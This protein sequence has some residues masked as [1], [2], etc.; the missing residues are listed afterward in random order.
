M[1]DTP[2]GHEQ[3]PASE[4]KL[5]PASLGVTH[6]ILVRISGYAIASLIFVVS[7]LIAA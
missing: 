1:K 6:L 2:A 7:L 5:A 3:L 4:L